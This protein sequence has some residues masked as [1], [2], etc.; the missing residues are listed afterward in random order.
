MAEQ[1]RIAIIVNPELPVGLIANTTGAVGIGLAA[2]FPQLAGMTLSDA[3]G[4]EI[5]VSSKLPVPILQA[6]ASQMREVLLKA[7]A[8]TDERAIV[9]FPAFARAMHSFQDYEV[10]FPLRSLIDEQLDGLGL[11]GP[12]KWVRSL[13]GS[14][15]L[16]R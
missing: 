8:L 7:L 12:E 14:L 4:K 1:M 16:L 15:K 11:V 5:D 10:A 3:A 9:P 13:T 2:K 6:N